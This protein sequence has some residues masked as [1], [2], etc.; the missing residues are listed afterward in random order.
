MCTNVQK[1]VS[2]HKYGD[3]MQENI[4]VLKY[5][6]WLHFPDLLKGQFNIFLKWKLLIALRVPQNQHF[7]AVIILHKRLLLTDDS[8]QLILP[9][10]RCREPHPLKMGPIGCPETSGRNYHYSLPNN[11][12]KCSS[13]LL[14][15]GGLKL[16][17]SVQFSTYQSVFVILG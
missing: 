9:I 7:K 8:G 12:E 17:L 4:F 13:D 14:R 2:K 10:F 5:H 6:F 15:G 11:P 3:V 1:Q 16:Y